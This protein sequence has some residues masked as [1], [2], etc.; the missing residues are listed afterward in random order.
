MRILCWPATGQITDFFMVHSP[1]SEVHDRKAG[2]VMEV[3][4][5]GEEREL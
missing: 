5:S 4:V 2:E 3:L 1:F